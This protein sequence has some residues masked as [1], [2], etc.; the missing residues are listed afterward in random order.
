VAVD[1]RESARV[2]RVATQRHADSLEGVDIAVDG[3]SW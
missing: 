1:Q 2:A 3:T